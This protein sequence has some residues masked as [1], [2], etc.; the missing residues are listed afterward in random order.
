MR[1]KSDDAIWHRWLFK[2]VKGGIYIFTRTWR[3][4]IMHDVLLYIP[5]ANVTSVFRSRVVSGMLFLCLCVLGLGNRVWSGTSLNIW[6]QRLVLISM[7]SLFQWENIKYCIQL[8]KA[9]G[10]VL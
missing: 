5:C 3:I 4:Y 1:P 10:S 7:V 2:R 6:Y 9:L 8:S